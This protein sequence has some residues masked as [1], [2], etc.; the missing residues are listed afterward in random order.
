MRTVNENPINSDANK[1][2]GANLRAQ[3]KSEHKGNSDPKF[4]TTAL[5]RSIMDYLD[6]GGSFDSLMSHINNEVGEAYAM[7][8]KKV[9]EEKRKAEEEAAKKKSIS[10]ARMDFLDSLLVYLCELGAIEEG[11][12]D[13]DAYDIWVDALEAVEDKLKNGAMSFNADPFGIKFK[14]DTPRGKRASL[15][16][17]EDLMNGLESFWNSL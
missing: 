1:I 7:H 10:L 3:T 5:Q 12:I 4:A 16:L 2:S 6:K 9:A 17:Y 11:S 8:E 13:S 15:N 14:F